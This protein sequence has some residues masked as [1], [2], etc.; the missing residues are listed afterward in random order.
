[1]RIRQVYRKSIALPLWLLLAFADHARADCQPL[2]FQLT[3]E[4]NVSDTPFT[5]RVYVMLYREAVTS[6]R[7]GPNWFRPD[8]FFARD[9]KDWKPSE[10]LALGKNAIGYPTT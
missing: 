8:P 3:F 7:S 1:M 4:K 10:P 6:L 5:G 2:E 9:V